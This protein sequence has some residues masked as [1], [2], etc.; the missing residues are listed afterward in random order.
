MAAVDILLVGGGLANGLIAARLQERRP[1]LRFLVLEA[2]ESIGGNHTWSFHHGDLDAAGHAFLSPFVAHRWSGYDVHFPKFSRTIP[3]GYAS[4]PADRFATVLADRCAAHLRTGARVRELGPGHVILEGGERLEARAVI[5]GRGAAPTRHLDLA[6]QKFV[7]QDLQLAAPHGLTRP[8]IMDA[9]VPQIDGYRFVYVLPLDER[10]LL[11]EDTYYADGAD[12]PMEAVRARIAAYAAA[13]GW[14][15]DYVIRE[16]NGVL[17]LALGGDIDAF[18][19]EAPQGLAR[20]GLRAALFHPTTGYSLPDAVALADLVSTAPDLSGAALAA[21]IRAHV[22]QTWKARGFFRL[23]NR[24]LFR[25][26]EP[27]QRYK[28]LERFYRLPEGLV[29]RF[30]GAD[31]TLADRARILTGRPPVP[32]LRAL[33][34]LRD[35]HAS[36]MPPHA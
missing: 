1:D 15:V 10:R 12:L 24:M 28:V 26:A 13:Q 34:C 7:G 17:P 2:G 22:A 19:E 30:Y 21:R 29:G 20:S 6:F 5:D 25:A 9:R 14:Q 33:G 16:E 23:L 11:V 31:L 36:R 4:I 27:G 18:L 3:T 35:A 8:V 32:V